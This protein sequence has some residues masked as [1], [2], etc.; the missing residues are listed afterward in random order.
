VGEKSNGLRMNFGEEK[1]EKAIKETE[2]K[3]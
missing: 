2:K 1:E 3:Q